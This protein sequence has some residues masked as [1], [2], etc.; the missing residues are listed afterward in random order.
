MQQWY[1]CP[2][3]GAP[4]AFGVRF[5]GHCR[6]QLN[7]PAQ[8]QPQPPSQYQ[9]QSVG[10][11]AHQQQAG[12]GQQIENQRKKKSPWLIVGLGVMTLVL[13]IG[14]IACAV[15]MTSQGT[16]PSTPPSTAQPSPPAGTLP[17]ATFALSTSV[18]PSGAGS[19]SPSSGQ[20]QQ[21]EQ[22]SVTASPSSG[23]TFSHWSGA[24]TDISLVIN[25]TMDSN[26]DLVAH[27]TKIAPLSKSEIQIIEHRLVIEQHPPAGTFTYVRGKVKNTGEVTQASLDVTIWVQYEVEG[28][29]GRTFNQP[30]SIDLQ[31]AAFKPGEVRDFD[32]LVQNGAKEGYQI[33]VSVT[34][35]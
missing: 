35:P 7:W 31:P 2:N 21:G 34:P 16:A 32:V 8:Q 14:G 18:N 26:K 4:V 28:L 11:Q 27:F 9:Q 15:G 13:L 10:W 33:S 29:E 1:Q 22:I 12:Y 25:V 6:T 30:G 23:Y 24:S 20:Y 17:P 5:C 3:C 19:V